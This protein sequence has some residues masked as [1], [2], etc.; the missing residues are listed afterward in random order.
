MK[1]IKKQ[2]IITICLKGVLAMVILSAMLGLAAC[3]ADTGSHISNTGA[4]AENHGM[5]DNASA[6][7]SLGSQEGKAEPDSFGSQ[8][9]NGE[10][11]SSSVPDH[12]ADQPW[13]DEPRRV[14]T[15][16]ELRGFEEY[17]N[18]IGNYGFL[19][20]DYKS[21]E[22]INLNEVFYSG[23]GLEQSPLTEEEREMYLKT[24]GQP[25]LYTDLVR[26]GTKQ[27]NGFLTEKT[28]LTL[29]QMKTGIGWIYLAPYDRYYAEHGDTNIRSFFCPS[30]EVDGGIY[31]I[32]CLSDGY[33][34]FNLE[35]IVTLKQ[36]SKGYQFLSNEI[37][38]DYHGSYKEDAK[39]PTAEALHYVI[40]AY[41]MEVEE[42]GT[43]IYPAGAVPDDYGSPVFD[44]DARYYSMEEME[45]ISWRP[46]LTAVFR[47]EI[48]ARQGYIFKSDFWNDFFSTF[49]WYSGEYPADSFDTGV[50]NEYEKANLK[51]AVEMEK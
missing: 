11:D 39:A 12:D 37:I 2:R 49:T 42:G 31:R 48:Y 30:G 41:K 22:Y 51:L 32:R 29:E 23:A 19:M 7:E 25:E 46:E 27:M 9:G 34:Q 28:G 21:P 33:S 15:Q 20:S 47:N 50:F 24:V 35:S 26:L 18:R 17:L 3:R 8:E 43:G 38:W 5:Q 40:S 6:P 10:P 1:W 45:Q 4:G 44:S 14:L 16:E 13:A 36:V